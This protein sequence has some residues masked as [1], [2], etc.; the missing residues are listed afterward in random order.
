MEHSSHY[1]VIVTTCPDAESAEKLA[2]LLNED[3][4]A[5]CVQV[6]SI[7]SFYSW[8]G[9]VVKDAEQLLLI[10]APADNYGRIEEAIQKNHP[11]EI[12]EIIELPIARGYAPYLAWIDEVS[13]GHE[14]PSDKT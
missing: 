7:T 3:R 1:S 8:K 13:T 4:L 5:A 11:Y 2:R 12:P 10:K 14:S 6:S 9:T